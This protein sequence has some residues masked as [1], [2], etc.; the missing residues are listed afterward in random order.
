M[1]ENMIRISNEMKWKKSTGKI[2]FKKKT[3]SQSRFS[4]LKSS[5]SIDAGTMR[6]ELKEKSDHGESLLPEAGI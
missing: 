6:K 5:P 4:Y 1:P 2:I 3:N